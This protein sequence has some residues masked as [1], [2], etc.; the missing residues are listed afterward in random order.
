MF[1]APKHNFRS[2]EHLS[3]HAVTGPWCD[4]SFQ[5]R[6]VYTLYYPGDIVVGWAT[7]DMEQIQWGTMTLFESTVVIKIPVNLCNFLS[8]SG[9]GFLSNIWFV[10]RPNALSFVCVCVCVCVCVREVSEK[11]NVCVWEREREG[12]G[13][14]IC[15]CHYVNYLE[16]KWTITFLIFLFYIWSCVKR[17][18]LQDFSSQT[19]TLFTDCLDQLGELA[20]LTVKSHAA[21]SSVISQCDDSD[22]SNSECLLET[23]ASQPQQH[24]AQLPSDCRKCMPMHPCENTDRNDKVIGVQ[25]QVSSD[26]TSRSGRENTV[27]HLFDGPLNSKAPLNLDSQVSKAAPSVKKVLNFQATE[28]QFIPHEYKDTPVNHIKHTVTQQRWDLL[29]LA[30]RSVTAFKLKYTLR[31]NNLPVFPTQASDYQ[32]EQTLCGWTRESQ[33]PK[34]CELFSPVPEQSMRELFKPGTCITL[35]RVKHILF[36]NHEAVKLIEMTQRKKHLE[37]L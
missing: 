36:M 34:N 4:N 1:T 5:G 31:T 19:V 24:H 7:Q 35:P 11:G 26:D 29:R 21:N 22:T 3:S 18:L 28:T 30:V 25:S 14:K 15:G 33:E 20:E 27:R 10:S 2:R 12:K 13:K 37:N 8:F 32:N 6:C 16:F 9:G 17:K 23:K